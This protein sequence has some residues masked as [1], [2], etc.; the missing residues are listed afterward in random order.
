[1]PQIWER[2]IL[3]P[4]HRTHGDPQSL[5]V[6]K[7][8]DNV[9]IQFSTRFRPA[10]PLLYS[11]FECRTS[12]VPWWHEAPL[13]GLHRS[14]QDGQTL[15]RTIRCTWS[16]SKR[17]RLPSLERGVLAKWHAD[18]LGQRR[19]HST[20]LGHTIRCTWRHSERPYFQGSERDVLIGWPAYCFGR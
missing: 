6:N 14:G 18:C 20:T 1:M 16:H 12:I 3:P 10:L 13:E 19:V 5:L 7:F 8:K 2:R 4:R 15:G 9:Y 17:P 11:P